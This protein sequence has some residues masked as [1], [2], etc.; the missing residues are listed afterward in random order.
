MVVKMLCA[1]LGKII[2][3]SAIFSQSKMNSDWAHIK[4]SVAYGVVCGR[5]CLKE[6]SIRLIA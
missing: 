6:S 4:D 5:L 1:L 3:V 2:E